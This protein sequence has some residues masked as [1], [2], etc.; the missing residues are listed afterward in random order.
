LGKVQV[1]L[2][3]LNLEKVTN[4]NKSIK[5]SGQETVKELDKAKTDSEKIKRTAPIMIRK[6]KICKTVSKH[7]NKKMRSYTFKSNLRR[8]HQ[9]VV[10]LRQRM[11]RTH[12]PRKMIC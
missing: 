2:R 12:Q 10:K 6:S 3:K 1:I 8:R 5:E 4:K 9:R 7:S 11:R